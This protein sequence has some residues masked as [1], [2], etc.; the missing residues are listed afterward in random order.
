MTTLTSLLPIL[1]CAAMMFGA[2]AISRLAR[3]A[4][5]RALL[6]SLRRDRADAGSGRERSATR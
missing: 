2:G 4:P 6:P 5:L 3:R 1:G